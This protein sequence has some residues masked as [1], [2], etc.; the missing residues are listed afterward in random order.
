[1]L[2]DKPVDGPGLQM[3][4]GP[5]VS[6]T[7]ISVESADATAAVVTAAG[8]AVIV[9]PMDVLDAGRMAVFTDPVGAIFSVW[10]PRAH[11]GAGLVGKA[12]ALCWN[13]LM[14]TDVEQSKVCYAKV[15]GWSAETQ[16][17]GPGQYTEFRMRAARSPG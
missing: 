2:R 6:P 5:P 15:F 9:P 13:E 3:N 16:G 12:G 1:M 10:Q 17:E 4:P 8:G 7:S 11:K 14:T